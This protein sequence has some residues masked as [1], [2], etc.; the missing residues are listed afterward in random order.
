MRVILLAATAL[1]P[2]F[3]FS[4][5]VGIGT[6]APVARL[7]VADSNV[8]FSGGISYSSSPGNTPTGGPGIRLM[9]YPDKAAIRAGIVS[10]T[11]WDKENIGNGSTAFGSN[12]I[13]SALGS[14]ATGRSAVASSISSMALGENAVA[15]GFASAAMGYNTTA[16]GQASFA[17]GQSAVASGFLS[18]SIGYN[19][20][21]SATYSTAFGNSTSSQGNGSFTMGNFTIAKSNYSLVIG[22][23]NDTTNT[24]RLFEIGMGIANNTR[25]NALT[26]LDNGNV[27]IGTVSPVRQLEIIGNSLIPVTLVIGNRAGFGAGSLEFVSDYGLANQWRPAYIV[28]SDAGSFT[29]SLDFYTNGTGAGSLY[30]NVKAL[31]LR[32][33]GTYTSSGTVG[34][35]S[36]IRIKE[37]IRPFTQG[38]DVITKINPVTFTYNSLAPFNTDKKQIG[39]I[40]QELEKVAPYMVDKS[41]IKEIDDLRSVNNQAYIFL[42]INAVKELSAQNEKQQKEIDT[43]K[44]LIKK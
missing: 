5:N 28:S 10:S 27:G 7:H 43:L 17:A 32:N 19:T 6:T 1:S 29:G 11:E 15:S 35:F 22:K 3:S 18:S 34:S 24:N 38:L 8:L 41:S 25:S 36:D 2:L 31:I 33:G 40:A 23:Y 42:L 39:I 12:T 30:G 37:N 4:Q 13:A 26:V 21:A 9:W 20:I 14:F 16:S 44:R